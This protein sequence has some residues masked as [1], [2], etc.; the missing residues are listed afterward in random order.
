MATPLAQAALKEM[1][2]LVGRPSHH[3]FAF[4]YARV[5]EMV[6]AAE[7]IKKLLEDP[8][9]VSTDVKLSDVT[10]KAGEGVGVVE[11]PRGICLHNYE[12][13]DEGIVTDA[14]IIVA[15][16][17]NIGGIEKSLMDAAKLVFEQDGLKK[18]KLPEPL[19]KT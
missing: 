13:D 2:D 8:D 5:I 12:C 10:P 18:L 16:N 6:Q 7:W 9:I 17:H 3:T 14:N 1:R 4:H 19:V 15:T 11:A